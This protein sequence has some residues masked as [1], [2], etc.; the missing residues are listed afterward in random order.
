MIDRSSCDLTHAA[1]GRVLKTM[2]N[3]SQVSWSWGQDLNIGHSANG[4]AVLPTH[5]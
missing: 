5:L 3:L 4:A 1:L 2:K